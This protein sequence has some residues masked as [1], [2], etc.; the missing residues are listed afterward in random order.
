MNTVKPTLLLL[1]TRGI[2]GNHG[3][4]ETFAER[5]ALYLVERGW[6]VTVYCQTDGPDGASVSEDHWNGVRRI[7]I[8]TQQ[9]GAKGTML[10]DFKAI[11]HALSE[12]G[13]PLV[14]GYNTAILST[15]LRL[16]GR[17]L[18]TN[19][20]GI[21][22]KRQKWS[23]SAKIWLW[24]NDWI[25]SLT[26]NLLIADHPE[27]ARHL[28]SRRRSDAIV[29]IPYGADRVERAAVELIKDIGLEPRGFLVSICRIE[30][31]NSVLTMLRG[32]KRA[33]TPLKFVCLGRLEP[34]TNSYHA[35]ILAEA[36]ENM[37]FPGPIY[38]PDILAAL[39]H[40]SFAYCHGHTVGGTNPSLVEA[41]GAGAPVIAHDN[42]FNRWTAGPGQM[43]FTDEGQFKDQLIRLTGSDALAD[44]S[45]K[46]ALQ[47]HDEA[48]RWP[49][50]LGAYEDVLSR[51]VGGAMP[52]IKDIK[53]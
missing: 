23:T 7:S 53:T 37:I 42:Q 47:R 41:L 1:G 52:V 10:F 40:F 22:W 12:P 2:P 13:I 45:R 19:M 6:E 31:E 51:Y 43:Y 25:G 50:I 48:F 8:P 36:N 3:G 24:L 38:A 15:L 11:R 35:A 4:F 21:E 30:P 46:A 5:L 32:F 17:T 34:D 9:A 27:I 20:D 26:S 28:T 14:L 18:I 44:E 33:G 49:S 39:R 29:T 16:R